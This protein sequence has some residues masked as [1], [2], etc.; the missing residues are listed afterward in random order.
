MATET[1]TIA[2]LRAQLEASRNEAKRLS[3]LATDRSYML[4]AIVPMLGP[5]ARQV[6]ALWLGA[7]ITRIHHSWEINPMTL[8][9]EEVAQLH[10][11]MEEACKSA[12]PVKNVDLYLADLGLG[13]T[14]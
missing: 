2:D 1:D 14:A 12:V 11:D 10:L 8:A 4:E 3:R 9:G 7:G 5:K 6:Y 13:G